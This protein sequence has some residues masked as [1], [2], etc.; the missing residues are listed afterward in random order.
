MSDKFTAACLQLNS[1]DVIAE[2]IA[3]VTELAR[4]ARGQGADLI[5]TPEVTSIVTKLRPDVI[6]STT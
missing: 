4:A 2:N 3:T 6:R 5:L 1:T